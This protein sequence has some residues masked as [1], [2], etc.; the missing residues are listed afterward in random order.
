M[1]STLTFPKN[2]LKDNSHLCTNC[3]FFFTLYGAEQD[4]AE[5]GA[6]GSGFGQDAIPA[7]SIQTATASDRFTLIPPGCCTFQFHPYSSRLLPCQIHAYLLWLLPL[8]DPPLFL[9][10]AIPARST[11]ISYG[12]YISQVQPYL[13]LLSPLPDPPLFP[14]AVTL[15]RSTLIYNGCYPCQIHPYFL[16]LLHQPDPTLFP[17][18]VTLGRSTLIYNGCYPCQIQ[19]YFLWL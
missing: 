7:R 3:I 1:L 18:A 6:S 17:M 11:L 4:S 15:G 8:P 2:P 14:M 10:A 16:W 9:M 12:C 5:Q 19:P 13:S